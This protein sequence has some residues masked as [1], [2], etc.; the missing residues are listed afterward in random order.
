MIVGDTAKFALITKNKAQ[1][2]FINIIE[3]EYKENKE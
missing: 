1:H 3:Y 2:L